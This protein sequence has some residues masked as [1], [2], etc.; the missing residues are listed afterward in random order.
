MTVEDLL[1]IYPSMS[2]TIFHFKL[3]ECEGIRDG[4]LSFIGKLI[5]ANFK[6]MYSII[7]EVRH[8]FP[9]FSRLAGGSNPN[10]DAATK[11][12]IDEIRF[13]LKQHAQ[14]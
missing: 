3:A 7:G 6:V 9:I 11:D 13:V 5:T 4:I 8:D 14:I 2:D 10:Y 1:K 12:W